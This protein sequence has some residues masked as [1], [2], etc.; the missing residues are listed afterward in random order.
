V[1]DLV[2]VFRYLTIWVLNASIPG[3]RAQGPEKVA[4]TARRPALCG[5]LQCAPRHQAADLEE[6]LELTAAEIRRQD[7]D[8]VLLQEVPWTLQVRDGAKFL[9]ERVGFNYL[10]LRAQGN[11]WA[12]LFEDGV[13]ILSRYPLKDPANVELKPREMFFEPRVPCR[14]G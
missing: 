1:T 14:R 2:G 12:I 6:R 8:L 3:K 9:A 7:A 11:R 4:R 10:Y 13:A 5:Y